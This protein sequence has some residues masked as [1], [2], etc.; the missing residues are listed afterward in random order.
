MSRVVGSRAIGPE[1]HRHSGSPHFSQRSKA[2]SQ[3]QIAARTMR[4]P[5]A[6]SAEAQDGFVAQPHRVGMPYIGA[7]PA[8]RLGVLARCLPEGRKTVVDV[9]GVFREVGMQANTRMAAR[10]MRGLAHQLP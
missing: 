5:R 9:R 3:P 1:T 7:D 6:G 4:H 10:Q 2:A 8:Q